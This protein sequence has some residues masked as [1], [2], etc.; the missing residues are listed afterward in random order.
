MAIAFDAATDGG[1]NGG[2]TTSLTFAHTCTGADRLLVVC[3]VGDTVTD[4]VTGVTYNG[5]SMTLVLTNAPGSIFNRFL[6]L[7]YLV[8]PATG[9]NNV[10]I[11][12]S[13]NHYLL[14]GAASYTGVNATGQ[15][16]NSAKQ[17][18]TA[19]PTSF[20]L[21]PIA[22]NCW[23]VLIVNSFNGSAPPTAGT[24]STRRTFDATFGGWGI[25]DSNGPITPPSSYNMQTSGY[26][27]NNVG[28]IIASF[29]PPGGAT[30][31][32]FRRRTQ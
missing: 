32:F 5:V 20:S 3:V 12:A 28:E 23:T 17:D 24:G 14:G 8:A 25:F 13:S 9:S 15:P 16:D 19:D 1:N 29:A 22:N 4:D 18:T 6:Y 30:G 10:V 7:F 31:F 11:S 27:G 26:G 21:T 2:T